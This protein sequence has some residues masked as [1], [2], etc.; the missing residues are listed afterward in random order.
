MVQQKSDVLHY[1]NVITTIVEANHYFDM[2]PRSFV[3]LSTS[4][5]ISISTVRGE[6]YKKLIVKQICIARQLKRKMEIVYISNSFEPHPR[7]QFKLYSSERIA[8]NE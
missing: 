2:Q 7:Q 6:M 5:L 8:V 4:P 1:T 3:R